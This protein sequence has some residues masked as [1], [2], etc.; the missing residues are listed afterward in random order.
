MSSYCVLG[1]VSN[2]FVIKNQNGKNIDE[3]NWQSRTLKKTETCHDTQIPIT[4]CHRN[5]RN[6]SRIYGMDT[7][8]RSPGSERASKYFGYGV[9]LKLPSYV[10]KSTVCKL[11]N[12]LFLLYLG[13]IRLGLLPVRKPSV[14]LSHCPTLPGLCIFIL[15]T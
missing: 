15:L 8:F 6:T 1:H 7:I 10:R 11:I 4:A 5:I 12:N 3:K 14:F 13:C 9:E 2:C